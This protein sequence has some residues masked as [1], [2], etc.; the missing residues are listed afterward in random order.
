[1]RPLRI[2]ACAVLLPSLAA[3][4]RGGSDADAPATDGEP[5]AMLAPGITPAELQSR[6]AQFAPATIEVDEAKLEPWHRQVLA[7]LIEASQVLHDVFAIQVSPQVPEWRSRLASESG[8]GKDAAVAYFDIMA[9]PWDRLR[10]DEPFLD[11]GPK[12]PGAGFYPEGLTQEQFE[13][14]IEAH[15]GDR[16]AFTSPV[17]L[18]RRQGDSSL[19]AVPYSQAYGDSLAK[20]AALLHEAAGIARAH[21][22]SLADF[23]DKRADAF[24]SNDYYA[25][26]LAWMDIHGSAIEPTIGPYEVYEDQLVGLKASFESFITVAD[27]AASAE[28]DELKSHLRELEGALPIEDRYKNLDRGFESPIRVVDVA[29]TAGDARRGVQTIAFNLPNDERVRKAKGSKK[30][31]LRNV[32]QAKFD[33]TL[34]PIAREVLDT[35]LVAEIA[36]EPWFTNVLMH[37][38][39]HGLGPGFITVNGQRTTV[40]QALKEQ[41]SAI[42]EAKAD[43]TGL[44]DMSV[45]AERGLYDADFVRRAYIGHLADMFRA[46]R[47]GTSEAHG[48][49]NLL[50]FNYLWDRG[51]IRYDSA[52]ARFSADLPALVAGNRAL[53]HEL[54]TLEARGSYQDAVDLLAKY[55]A[56]IRPEMKQAIDRLT[57]VPVDIRPVYPAAGKVDAWSR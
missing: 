21:N 8:A 17:T 26:D 37:E 5:I 7:K 22:A 12:P 48:K 55:A 42:E 57:R 50:Q 31:M 34:V 47:F 49:A 20:A 39:A 11:V 25:S 54:L 29:F 33:K 9:G 43:V 40:N 44:H 27:S 18:I 41:Y 13:A 23:L 16:D 46:V 30:V 14:W 1:M 6:V 28:L 19:V 32:S 38:L 15:P 4:A 3:C 35:A 45:L 53:A 10:D 36:F 51:A 24:G 56:A 52:T 2:A